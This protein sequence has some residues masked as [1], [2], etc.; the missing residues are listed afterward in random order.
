MRGCRDT[1]G[2]SCFVVTDARGFDT[3]ADELMPGHDPGRTWNAST[4]L[5]P[6]TRP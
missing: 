1:T 6:Y 2:R 4:S 3:A 5:A